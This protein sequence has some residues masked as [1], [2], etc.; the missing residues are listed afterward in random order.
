MD[1]QTDSV[2]ETPEVLAETTEVDAPEVGAVEDTTA[3]VVDVPETVSDEAV[4]AADSDETLTSLKARLSEEDYDYVVSVREEA[5]R[6][7]QER[8]RFR[9]AFEG[10]DDEGV[11]AFL[12]AVAAIR[13]DPAMAHE[14]FSGLVASLADAVGITEEQAQD[15]INDEI[16]ED[17]ELSVEERIEKALADREAK[18]DA[19]RAEADRKKAEDEAVA[20]INKETEALG[21][22]SDLSD[23][24]KAIAY[25]SLLHLA[26]EQTNGNLAEADKLFKARDQRIIDAAL[27]GEV[28]T[29]EAYPPQTSGSGSA[30]SEARPKVSGLDHAAKLAKSR[31]DAEY[32]DQTE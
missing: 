6:Y 1:E 22:T 27:A 11:D 20:E 31:L 8:N 12:G 18:A 19:E 24:D 17:T 21:Y 23:P 26:A 9:E 4:E 25:V 14:A 10:F 28:T 13:N 3:E 5:K 15:L 16:D 29:S 7:R 32:S 30:G 2:S